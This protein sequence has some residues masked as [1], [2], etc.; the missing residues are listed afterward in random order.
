[1]EYEIRDFR[2][3]AVDDDGNRELLANFVAQI[4]EETRYTDG[5]STDTVLTIEGLMPGELKDGV[6]PEDT[7][8]KKLPP[9]RV[10]AEAF[11]GLTWVMPNWG[12]T[13]VIRPGTGVKDN[14]RTQIQL[15]SQPKVSTIYRHLGWTEIAGQR[16]FLHNGGAI[17]RN[18]NRKD[19]QVV[20]PNELTR[21][22]LDT[23]HNAHTGIKATLDL[24]EMA[25]PEITWPLLA[26]T[27]V[28]LFGP[29]DF[30]LHLTGRTGTY[31][32]EI[33]SLFQ[34]HYGPQMDAR[35]LPG[36]WSSTAN[37]IEAQAFL[38]ANC[39]F[40]VD[41]FVPQGTSWQI[42]A[43]QATADKIIRAQ[44]NQAGRARLTDTS[45]LQTAMYP[46]GIVLSTG[47]DTPE[48]HSVRARMLILELSPGDIDPAKLTAAQ[49]RRAEY[50]ATVAHLASWLA[51]NPVTLTDR[52]QEIRDQ[53]LNIGHSRTPG[54]LGMLIATIEAFLQF[55]VE[56]KAVSP[57]K[58]KALMKTASQAIMA[59]GEKQQSYLEAADPVDLFTAALRQVMATGGGHFRTLNGGVP[60]GALQ[61]G[62]TEESSLGDVPVWKSRGPTLGWVDWSKD[63]LFL[64]ATTGFNVVRK[65]AGSEISLTKQTLMK[66]LK[67]AGILSRTDDARQRNTVRVTAEQHPRQVL[68]LILSEAL[69]NNEAPQDEGA[70]DE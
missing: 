22:N 69:D 55:A 33:M 52:A 29:V 65:A 41:D 43:Y 34:S 45:S 46:R 64:D 63:E 36:S 54:M 32:S 17:G 27:L 30:A 21:Y 2:T 18:G 59:A 37:A 48:G 20:V 60:R 40:V 19:I 51:R 11:S 15:S 9:V 25:M 1:M 67:D 68:A 10:S 3:F 53:N 7:P 5:R 23:E 57:Q 13:A 61:L 8:P 28:P 4:T 50:S 70:E 47:E 58:A 12:V 62:W 6:R 38:A 56:E 42:R 44:G 24:M 14:L 31:K 66:R 35:H 26:A 16:Y 49:Q 39:A